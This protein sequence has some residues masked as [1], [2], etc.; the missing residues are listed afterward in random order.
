[1]YSE[2]N[3]YDAGVKLTRD[4]KL[5]NLDDVN[6]IFT[7]KEFYTKAAAEE[8]LPTDPALDPSWM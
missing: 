5:D 1:M 4:A 3:V 2:G 6:V 8:P 7:A